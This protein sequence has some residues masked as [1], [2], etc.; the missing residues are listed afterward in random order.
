[1]RVRISLEDDL[2]ADLDRRV[3][4]RQRSAFIAAAIRQALEDV[5]RWDD[6]QAALGSLKAT[7]H[8]WDQDPAAWVRAQ[9]R[10]ESRRRQPPMTREEAMAMRG[11]NAT[12]EP[13]TDAH[14]RGERE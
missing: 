4:R 3:G 1:M 11:A 10:G 13:P 9:R 14:P 6:I 5:E 8:E 7:G 12:L 2:I